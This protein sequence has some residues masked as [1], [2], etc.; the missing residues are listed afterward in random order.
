MEGRS[1]G[2]NKCY[3]AHFVCLKMHLVYTHLMIVWLSIEFFCCT[4][5]SLRFLKALTP[6]LLDSNIATETF[7]DILIP[8][9]LLYVPLFR[10]LEA[11]RTSTD[12][13]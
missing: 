9:L 12:F 13:H 11:S 3:P 10:S 1:G 2:T 4:L 5:P 6:C 7:K 8:N